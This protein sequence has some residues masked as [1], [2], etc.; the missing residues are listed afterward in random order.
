V[1]IVPS[2]D[3]FAADIADRNGEPKEGYE[4]FNNR[5]R[6]LRDDG[7]GATIVSA[8]AARKYGDATGVNATS[9]DATPEHPQ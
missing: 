2:L 5:N 8:N 6:T 9:V 3:A 7:D 1:L 4:I